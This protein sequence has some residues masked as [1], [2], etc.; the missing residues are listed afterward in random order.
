MN[1][2]NFLFTEKYRPKTL[3][4]LIVP[5]MKYKQKYKL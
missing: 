5:K 2:N 3:N 1:I 4:E